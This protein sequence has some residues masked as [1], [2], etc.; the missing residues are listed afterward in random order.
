MIT[1]DSINFFRDIPP[2]QFLDESTLRDIVENLSLEFSPKNSLILTQDGPAS[3]CLRVIKK[4]GVKVYL[5]NDD[6]IVLDY[7]SEGDSFGYLSLISGDK[8]RTN[9]QAIEDTLCYQIPR[10]TVLNIVKKEPLFGEYFMKSFFRNYMDKTYREMRNKNLLF[11]EGEKLLYTT[12]VMNIAS[13]DVIKAPQTTSIKDA[14]AIMSQNKISSLVLTGEQE[15][16]AGIITDTDLRDRVVASGIDASAP[17][18]EI[19]SSKLVTID[20]G[21]TCFDALSTMIRLNIHH[22]L[23]TDGQNIT[24]VVTNHDFM[25]LQG[26]SPLSI[27]KNIDRQNSAEDLAP[28][29]DRIDQTISILLQEGVRASYIL[30]IITE[31]HDRL[32]IKIIELCI[33]K[34]GSPHCPFAF[35]VYGSEGRREETFKTVLHC[36]FAYDD[37]KTF[38]NKRDIEE[39]CRQLTDNLQEMIRKCGLPEFDTEPLGSVVPIYGDISEWESKIIKAFRSE[40]SAHIDTVIK[41][42]DARTIYGDSSIVESLKDRVYKQIRENEKYRAHLMGQKAKQKSPVGFFKKFVVD[43]QGEKMEKLDAKEKGSSHIVASVRAMAIAHN[44]KETST[45]ERLGILA[46]REFINQELMNNSVAAL[47]FLL[48]ILMQSQLKKKELHQ[49]IDNCI[50]PEKLSLLEKRTLKETFQIIEPLQNAAERSFRKENAG[51]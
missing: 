2:F 8:T 42:L 28:I 21:S 3:D 16:P 39:F 47:E 26:I 6:D 18:R 10:E 45:I 9:I 4:G 30:R 12:P 19:M 11:K 41:M 27:L 23:V 37:E 13:C 15:L 25:L 1:E 51:V 34:M 32:I 22:L 7:K 29:R 38:C 31:L 36:A 33:G 48:H 5:S 49:K 14:A 40:N 20:S 44:I 24:G 43:N 50:E 17:A 46:K 35:F